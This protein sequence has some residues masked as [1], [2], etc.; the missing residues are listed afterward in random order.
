MVIENSNT[1]NDLPSSDAPA[2]DVEPPATA[3]IP[4]TSNPLVDAPA[5]LDEAPAVTQ[6]KTDD[7]PFG[8]ERKTDEPRAVEQPAP[9]Q[10]SIDD[11]FAADSQ[12]AQPRE[13]ANEETKPSVADDIFSAESHIE[14][15]ST[16]PSN[17]DAPKS[18]DD[19][20]GAETAPSKPVENT[21]P[22][23][24]AASTPSPKAESL[25]DIFGKPAADSASEK[26]LAVEGKPAEASPP[27]ES[28]ID[29]IFG[30]KPAAIQAPTSIKE[31]TKSTETPAT[32]EAA[33]GPSL[34]DLFGKPVS[35]ELKDVD[36]DKLFDSLFDPTAVPQPTE[37]I[38]LPSTT[39]AAPPEKDKGD[40]LDKL[41]GIGSFVPPSEF[42]GAEF[43]TWVD[44][45]GTY[46][47]RARLVVIYSD[48]VKLIKEN[49]KF[50]TVPINRL[51]EKDFQYVQWVA[52]NLTLDTN[53]KFVKKGN[54]S[55]TDNEN[56]R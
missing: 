42:K 31:S 41:F 24:P 23:E 36:V 50:T 46:T 45:T 27:K 44:N 7:D 48:R 52:S 26:A 55:T 39:P 2:P 4:E 20:F 43:Q 25:D 34:D 14:P 40:E 19:I 16:E 51:S 9:S 12:P 10:A 18:I 30:E 11:L 37:K 54:E 47:V 28:S 29:E 17:V 8:L 53:K 6:P 5:T 21:L 32:S 56:V 13:I 38:D 3:V 49:G 15:K 1:P 22:I 33:E 35:K